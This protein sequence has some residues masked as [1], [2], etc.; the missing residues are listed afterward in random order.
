MTEAIEFVK[1]HAEAVG[2]FT[3]TRFLRGES[4]K[5]KAERC[6]TYKWVLEYLEKF[7][8]Y[9]QQVNLKTGKMLIANVLYKFP[10]PN[11]A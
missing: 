11:P 9:V 10:A 6:C 5:P 2:E 8:K 3:L 7:P 1:A 4:K